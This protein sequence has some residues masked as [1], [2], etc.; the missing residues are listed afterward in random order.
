[1]GDPGGEG[2]CEVVKMIKLDISVALFLY[3]FSTVI[4]VFIL[5]IWLGR[6][7][8]FNVFKEDRQDVWQCSVCSYVYRDDKKKVLS[9]CPQCKS[10]NKKEVQRS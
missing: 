10:I 2:S 6:S 3:L 9:R 5:W 1:M 8:R 4:V 7:S